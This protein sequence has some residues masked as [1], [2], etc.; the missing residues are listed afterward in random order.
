MIRVDTTKVVDFLFNKG[1]SRYWPENPSLNPL[2][3]YYTYKTGDTIIA[4][5]EQYPFQEMDFLEEDWPPDLF[6]RL[7]EFL[8]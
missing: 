7:V 5:D 2:S 1:F 3:P 6:K 4:L 8:G